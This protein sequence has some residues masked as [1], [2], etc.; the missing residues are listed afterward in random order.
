VVE[1][2]V[3]MGERLILVGRPREVV[4][5]RLAAEDSCGAHRRAVHP[6]ALDDSGE[7]PSGLPT[8]GLPE[9]ASFSPGASPTSRIGPPPEEGTHP[10]PES[11][12]G[13][14]A[15]VAGFM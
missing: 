7:H 6:D 9:M 12:S 11:S 8:N 3:A 14:P 2:R 15:Q 5:G 13:Q 4:L 1:I 10:A